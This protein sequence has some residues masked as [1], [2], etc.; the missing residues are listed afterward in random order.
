[1]KRGRILLACA[2]GLTA[3]CTR[4]F[5]G[6]S[7]GTELS[8]KVDPQCRSLLDERVQQLLSRRVEIPKDADPRRAVLFDVIFPANSVE[9][10]ALNK[11]A[12]LGIRFLSK[13]ASD[14]P[15][16]SVYYAMT[17]EV[18]GQLFQFPVFAR[19]H[20][21]EIDQPLSVL[22]S[23][24]TLTSHLEEIYVLAPLKVLRHSGEFGLRF[25]DKTDYLPVSRLPIHT[26]LP[27][28]DQ[29]PQP[30]P[31]P[32]RTPDSRLLLSLVAK[33]YC[34]DLSTVSPAPAPSLR[35][36]GPSHRGRS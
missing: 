4:H 20:P 26:A 31:D 36:E 6:P 8:S 17:P 35:G 13:R 19:T 1:M 27:F 11:F 16:A 12:I 15:V 18:R 3:G 24:K 22:N 32:N 34:R 33:Y 21:Q 5:E 14:F 29:D 30:E 25:K 7:V 23:Q 2:L 10:R 9:Y 28:A